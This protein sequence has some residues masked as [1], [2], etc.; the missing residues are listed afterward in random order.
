[1]PVRTSPRA[2][3]RPDRVALPL[4]TRATV[5]RARAPRQQS[6][7]DLGTPLRHV[8]FCVVDLETTGTSPATCAITEV[9]AAKY[10][11]GR[12]VGTFQTL[13]RL[14]SILLAQARVGHDARAVAPDHSVHA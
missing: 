10:V 3:A 8:T 4:A 1:M 13:A 9:G 2:P 11:G 14:A 6:F 5:A 12:C 7:D